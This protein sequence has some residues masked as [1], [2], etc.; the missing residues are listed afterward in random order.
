[1]SDQS[2][3]S[4]EDC[5]WVTPTPREALAA[6]AEVPAQ[7]EDEPAQQPVEA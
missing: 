1:M 6:E 5:S 7:R 3:W 2:Y 4:V